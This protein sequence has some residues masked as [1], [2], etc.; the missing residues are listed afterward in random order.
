M[1]CAVGANL[2]AVSEAESVFAKLRPASTYHRANT[3]FA[4]TF[5]HKD[6]EIETNLPDYDVNQFL[7]N[8]Y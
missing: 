8:I 4:P 5:T 6:A 3:R 7:R 2:F 1:Y